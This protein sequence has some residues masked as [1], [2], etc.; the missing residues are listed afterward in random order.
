[1]V[2]MK[3]ELVASLSDVEAVIVECSN[4]A[5]RAQVKIPVR[6]PL[7]HRDL[8]ILPLVECP[9]CRSNF[10]STLLD[11]VR[12][13]VGSLSAHHGKEKVSLL[14]STEDLGK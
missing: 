4:S 11:Y 2:C 14:L 1:M 6:A 8:R 3:K 10:D 13:F 12:A 9:V 7:V 5:C